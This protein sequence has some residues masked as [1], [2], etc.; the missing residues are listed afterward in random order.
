MSIIKVDFAIIGAGS[1]G[2]QL[3]MAMAKD[4]YFDDKKIV[5]FDP[6]PKTK[7]DRTWSYWEIGEGEWDNHLVNSWSL[8]NFFSSDKTLSIPTAPYRYKTL[9]SIDFYNQAKAVLSQ[10]ENILWID[11]EVVKT[12]EMDGGLGLQTASGSYNSGHCF[13]SRID[14]AFLNEMDGKIRI[15]Q[16]FKGRIVRFKKPVFKPEEFTI[17]DFRISWENTTSFVYVL[18]KNEY[19]GMIEYTFFTKETVAEKVYDEMLDRYI[20]AYLSKDSYDILEE[21][22]GV[23]PMSN[24]KFEVL[25]TNSLTKIGTAGGWVRGSTGY[26]FKRTGNYVKKIIDNIRAEDLP[27]KGLIKKRYGLFD[28]LLLDILEKRNHIMPEIFADIYANNP[29]DRVFRFLD[30]E[31]TIWDDF[32][33]MNSVKPWPFLKAIWNQWIIRN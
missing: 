9:R 33:I 7:N 1:A 14:K 2:L 5:L 29:I 12:S 20:D 16:H 11:E 31:T 26:A 27:S 15:L 24:F 13:D 32:R 28:T 23:I 17:M 30:G 6:D 4:S 21:E 3:A 18:P 10:K 22:I 19:E 8:A 25:N